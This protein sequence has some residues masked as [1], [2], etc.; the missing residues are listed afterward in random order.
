[1]TPSHLHQK[2]KVS[3]LEW[4]MNWPWEQI[5]GLSQF[6]SPARLDTKVDVKMSAQILE[7]RKTYFEVKAPCPSIQEPGF[8]WEQ[9]DDWDIAVGLRERP[10]VGL[11]GGSKLRY[12]PG[13]SGL[14]AFLSTFSK[15]LLWIIPLAFILSLFLG[16]A[17]V[18]AFHS[19]ENRP[20]ETSWMKILLKTSL[21]LLFLRWCASTVAIHKG[22]SGSL[23]LTKEWPFLACADCKKAIKREA[24][25]EKF[26]IC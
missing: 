3:N 17:V 15:D 22:I 23:T 26:T 18:V 10:E 14:I 6:P 20:I 1:M 5:T 8:R 16:T 24:D 11:I 21:M 12:S 19:S 7:L 13:V 9:L 4:L 2:S 25:Q